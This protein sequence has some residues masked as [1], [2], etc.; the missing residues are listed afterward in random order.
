M[1]EKDGNTRRQDAQ[2]LTSATVCRRAQQ[3][4]GKFIGDA[5]TG[6]MR[7]IEPSW[8]LFELRWGG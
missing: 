5:S 4:T 1:E 7:V 6:S 3:L 8:V 2:H